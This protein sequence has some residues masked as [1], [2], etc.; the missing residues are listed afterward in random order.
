[1]VHDIKNYQIDYFEPTKAGKSCR[2]PLRYLPQIQKLPEQNKIRLLSLVT[3]FV[4]P[5]VIPK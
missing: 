4:L 1:M 3:S 5:A 2:N